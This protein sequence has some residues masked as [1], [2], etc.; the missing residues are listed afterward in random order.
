MLYKLAHILRDCF[1]WLW[2]VVG[3]INSMLFVLRYRSRFILI[4]KILEKYGHEDNFRIVPLKKDNVDSLA[5]F[6]KRQPKSAFD[7]FK[8]H[9]FDRKS[10]ITLAKD[11]SFLA[12]LV[13]N[14]HRTEFVDNK[15]EGEQVVGYFFLRSFF[16]GKC[17]RGYITDFQH[18]RMGINKLMGKCATDIAVNFRLPMFGT[19]S[20]ENIASMKSA[21]TVNKVRIIKTLDNGDYYVEYLPVNF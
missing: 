6:F 9:E 19:I 8:P 14:K 2:D 1:P 17:Y 18:R 12:F 10:L 16:F 13:I 3:I 20:P 4:P 5:E 11:K 7:Y 15:N 21:E